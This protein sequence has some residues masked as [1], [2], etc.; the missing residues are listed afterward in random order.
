MK[1]LGAVDAPDLLAQADRSAGRAA[2]AAGVVVSTLG[3]LGSLR[4]AEALLAQ[5]WSREAG[6]PVNLDVLRAL[7]HAG[8]YVAGALAGEELIGAVAG[9]FG[10][11]DGAIYLHSH[12]LA[13]SEGRR[14]RGVGLALKLHQRSWALAR[15]IDL[16]TWTFDPLVRRNAYFNL[17][18]LGADLQEYRVGFYG[19]MD[20]AINGGDDSDRAL[21]AWRLTSA[22]AIAA[23]DGG[24]T[25]PDVAA[26]RH[27]GVTV[28]LSAG[29]DGRPRLGERWGSQLLCQIPDDIVALRRA[30]PQAAMSWR[31]ALRDVLTEALAG[32]YR[33]GGVSRSG[34]YL[35]ARPGVTAGG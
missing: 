10:E 20:D 9:F 18:K 5:T 8:S 19:A 33:V 7:S 16:V 13:V 14:A 27:R 3:D 30:D 2:A 23:G 15:G 29:D 21:T 24:W 28:A 31:R 32:G 25:E 17:T 26:L 35:L 6:P 34:W 11:R 4:R 12:I 22:R 1:L